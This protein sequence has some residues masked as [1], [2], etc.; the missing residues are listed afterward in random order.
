MGAGNRSVADV[1][2]TNDL[3]RTAKSCGPGIP[4]LMPSLADDDLRSDGGKKAG[5]RGDHV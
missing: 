1:A 2:R 3:L 5:P 4:V